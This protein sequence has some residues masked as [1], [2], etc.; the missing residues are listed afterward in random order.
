M[1]KKTLFEKKNKEVDNMNEDSEDSSSCYEDCCGSDV[2]MKAD[3]NPE[4]F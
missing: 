2:T 4:Q 3:R 1:E